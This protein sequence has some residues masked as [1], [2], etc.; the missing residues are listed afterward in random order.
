MARKI[1]I[2]DRV[3]MPSDRA[4]RVAFWLDVVAA[5]RSFYANANATSAVVGATQAELDALKNGSVVERVEAILR[6]AGT[7][8][9]AM[10]TTLEARH[11]QYQ[12]ELTDRNPWERY[13]TSWD[14]T[15]WTSVTVA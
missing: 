8:Q 4:F 6:P 9:A 7:S 5:R 2:L 3:G 12:Q 1:I 15:T 13:G 11:A 14:G 10:Q